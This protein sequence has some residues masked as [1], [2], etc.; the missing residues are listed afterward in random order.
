MRPDLFL[1][2]MPLP[3]DPQ[4]LKPKKMSDRNVQ[5]L[6]CLAFGALAIVV[7]GSILYNILYPPVWTERLSVLNATGQH[8]TVTEYRYATNVSYAELI[9]FLHNDTT[10]LADYVS[11]NYTCGDFAVHLH[12]DAE[13]QGIRCGIVGVALNAS[14]YTGLDARYVVPARFGAGNESDTGHGFTVFNT[15]DKGLV[16][17]DATGITSEEKAQGRQPHYMIVYFQQDMPLGEIWI[18]Q[19]ESLDYSY[20]QQKENLYLAYDQK[21]NDYNDE[22]KDFNAETNAFNQTFKSYASDREAFDTEYD[23]FSAELNDL[24]DANVSGDD[25]PEQLDLWREGLIRWQDALNVKLGT[26]K[27]QSNELDAKKR[28]LHEKRAEL[29]QSEEADW[30]MTRPLGVVD[31]VMV[32]W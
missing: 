1:P 3:E 2:I 4:D 23:R 24:V 25:M 18:N 11:P 14:G 12:D 6:V 22:V 16:Y 19:S 13:A 20:F 26:I 10:Y 9:S 29:E 31:N 21:I 28:L 17:I 32:Y 30:E 27:T 8:L 7:S 5:L 15:T